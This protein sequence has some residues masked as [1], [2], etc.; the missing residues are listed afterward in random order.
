MVRHDEVPGVPH[1]V[2]YAHISFGLITN[3]YK[4]LIETVHF[5]DKGCTSKNYDS[6]LNS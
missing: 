5:Y 2:K 3:F 1:L 6:I 4:C